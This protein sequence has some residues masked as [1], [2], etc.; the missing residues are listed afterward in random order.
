MTFPL[1]GAR[2]NHHTRAKLSNLG[3][4]GDDQ[5]DRTFV[6][7][8]AETK[9]FI[10]S[11]LPYSACISQIR[12]K[13]ISSTRLLL[14]ATSMPDIEI[15]PETNSVNVEI[16]SLES[17]LI[18]CGDDAAKW[19]TQFINFED[20][21]FRIA[22]FDNSN[23]VRDT[24]ELLV[25]RGYISGPRSNS[26]NLADTASVNITTKQSFDFMNRELMHEGAMPVDN[27]NFRSNIIIDTDSDAAWQEEDWSELRIG[28]AKV[29]Y[30][31]YCDRCTLPS[32]D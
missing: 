5:L 2:G 11:K 31:M 16:Y 22:F 28:D 4:I 21:Q 13:P 14:S 15:S 29:K 1:K 30:L 20:R 19:V 25:E 6:V 32:M 12:A 23:G 18:D 26:I 10:N 27:N 17:N 3:I 9:K 8:D 24:G 7:Y